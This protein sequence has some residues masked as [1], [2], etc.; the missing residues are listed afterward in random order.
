MIDRDQ[1]IRELAYAIWEHE[2]CAIG[3]A[4]RHW[5]M[6]KKAIEIVERAGIAVTMNANGMR[7]SGESFA[8]E[9]LQATF[10]EAAGFDAPERFPRI[11]SS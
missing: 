8:D 7:R 9:E 6:A 2:G 1:Q 10:D 4:D 3:Q 11:K 5:E